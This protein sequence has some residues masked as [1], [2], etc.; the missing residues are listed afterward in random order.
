[1]GERTLV[2]HPSSFIFSLSS[3][4]LSAT[5]LEAVLIFFDA[6]RMCSV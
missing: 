3:Y 6:I 1:M 2:E 4:E 5:G